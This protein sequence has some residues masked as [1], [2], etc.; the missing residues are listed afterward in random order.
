MRDERTQSCQYGSL[1]AGWI[2]RNATNKA[3]E[4][5]AMGEIGANE[6][7]VMPIERFVRTMTIIGYG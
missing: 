4:T 1:G 7:T 6:A 2:G 5:T 3:T